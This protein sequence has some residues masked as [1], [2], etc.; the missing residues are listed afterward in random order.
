MHD[1]DEARDKVML[2]KEVKSIMLT[3]EDKKLIAYHES[4]HA[5]VQ[6]FYCQKLLTLFTK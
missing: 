5:F 3:P 2:G 6:S 1:F 4:G